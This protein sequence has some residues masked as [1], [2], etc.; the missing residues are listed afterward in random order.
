MQFSSEPNLS[1]CLFIPLYR[2]FFWQ[3]GYA[4]F[5]VSASQ[6]NA[7]LQYLEAQQEHHR[8]RMFQ[9][10]YREV[11]RKHGVQFDEHYV[12]D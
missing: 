3:R 9:E 1:G 8:T 10:K 4:A 5:S 2:A 7:V 6:L 11:L 12:W